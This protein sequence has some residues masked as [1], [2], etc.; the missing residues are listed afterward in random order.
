MRA[1]ERGGP[2]VEPAERAGS[3]ADEA[4]EPLDPA[5]AP[6][7]GGVGVACGGRLGER[8]GLGVGRGVGEHGV[9]EGDDHVAGLGQAGV[10]HEDDDLEVATVVEQPV[11]R[12]GREPHER[13]GSIGVSA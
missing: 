6:G 10:L 2:L 3:G 11:D 5:V 9:V 4:H 13:P 7:A 12:A 8:R 1:D